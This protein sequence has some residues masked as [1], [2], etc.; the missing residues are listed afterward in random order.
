MVV[1]VGYGGV[2]CLELPVSSH[3]YLMVVG[4]GFSFII[5]R[6]GFIHT[7]ESLSCPPP[8]K[9]VDSWK[10]DESEERRSNA[11]SCVKAE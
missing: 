4:G 2:H 7:D 10:E 5:C 1:Q 8:G 3:N 9:V 6:E 11:S